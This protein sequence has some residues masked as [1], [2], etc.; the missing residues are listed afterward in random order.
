[1]KT[2][3]KNLVNQIEAWN[4]T[5]VT[6]ERCF[7]Y[8]DTYKLETV[9]KFLR[10]QGLKYDVLHEMTHDEFRKNEGFGMPRLEV[11]KTPGGTAIYGHFIRV[12]LIPGWRPGAGSGLLSEQEIGVEAAE[13]RRSR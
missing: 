11:P 5:R 3:Y 4:N 2:K 6:V 9:T 13:L 8:I 7:L 12:K 1:M 10:S